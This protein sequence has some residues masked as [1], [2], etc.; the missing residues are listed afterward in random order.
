MK[1]KFKVIKRKSRRSAMVHGNSPYAKRYI[2]G[3]R[4]WADENTLGILV[5]KDRCSAEVWVE[6]WRDAKDLIVVAVKPLGRGKTVKLVANDITTE[7]LD[8]F[9]RSY[10]DLDSFGVSS[11]PPVN[12]MAYPGVLVLE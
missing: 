4:V 11:Q 8:M 2:E 12:T 1:P 7:A 6:G 3:E 5:F 10:E 9:Y